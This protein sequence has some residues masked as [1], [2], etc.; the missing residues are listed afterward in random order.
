M[1]WHPPGLI[2][3]SWNVS[4]ALQTG[5]S[6]VFIEFLQPNTEPIILMLVSAHVY[7]GVDLIQQLEAAAVFGPFFTCNVVERFALDRQR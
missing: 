2:L 3:P 1:P 7:R 6:A 5:R 4:H